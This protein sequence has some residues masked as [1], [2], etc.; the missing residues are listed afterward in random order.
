MKCPKCSY[1]SE[2]RN[3]WCPGCGATFSVA[4]LERLHQLEYLRQRLKWWA[5]SKELPAAQV[6]GVLEEVDSDIA[7]LRARLLPA[8]PVQKEQEPLAPPAPASARVELPAT[9]AAPPPAAAPALSPIA[10][11]FWQQPAASEP[12]ARQPM[13]PAPKPQPT[14]PA[15]AS[16]RAAASA[17]ANVR[18]PRPKEI[19][20]PRPTAPSLPSISLPSISLPKFKSPLP[21]DF[22]WRQLGSYLTSETTL[23]FLLLLGSIAILISSAVIS[24]GNPAGLGPWPHLGAVLFTTALFYG[25]G[26]FVLRRLKQFIPGTALLAIGGAFIALDIFTLGQGQLLRWP[27]ATIWLVASLVCL[28]AYAASH[29]VLRDRPFAILTTLAGGSLVLS[30]LYV[31]GLPLEWIVVTLGPLAIAYALASQR[32]RATRPQLAWAFFWTP[33]AAVPLMMGTLTL[34]KFAAPQWESAVGAEA[35]EYA[36]GGAWWLGAGYYALCARL[37]GGRAYTYLAAWLTPLAFLLTL[38]KAPWGAEWYGACLAALALAYLVFGVVRPPVLPATSES[39]LAVRL[40]IQPVYQV[41]F[42]LTLAALFWPFATLGATALALFL[43]AGAYA[44]AYRLFHLPACRYAAVYLPA[45]GLGFALLAAGIEGAWHS[46]GFAVLALVYLGS[47]RFVLRVGAERAAPDLVRILAREP[48][49]QVAALLTVVATFWPLQH[50]ESR[51][52]TLVLLLSI[53]WGAY[54]LWRLLALRYLAAYLPPVVAG[55]TLLQLAPAATVAGLAWHNA[56]YAALALA[57]LLLGHFRLAPTGERGRPGLGLALRREPL[58]QVATLLTVLALAWPYS[59]MASRPAAAWLVF[60]TYALAAY[61]WRL[62]AP[63]YVAAYLLPVAAYFSLEQTQPVILAWWG[64]GFALLAVGYLL[65]GRF[66]LDRGRPTK[67]GSVLAEPVYQVAVLLTGA[68]LAWPRSDYGAAAAAFF[69]VAAGYALGYYLLRLWALRY[70]AAYALPMAVGLTV[71]ARAWPGDPSTALSTQTAIFPALALAYLL[72]GRFALRVAADDRGPAAGAALALEPIYQVA[73]LLTIAPLT[74]AGSAKL[75]SVLPTLWLAFAVYA[76]GAYL[77]CWRPLRYAA[78]YLLPFAVYAVV[79]QAQPAPVAWWGVAA[80][81]LALTYLLFGRFVLGL[82]RPTK[83]ATVLAEP[84]YQVAGLLSFV[85]VAWPRSDYGAAAGA[86]FLVATGYALGYYLLR[87]WALRYVAA[88][89]LPVAVGLT[90]L[91]RAWPG[92]A[93]AALSWREPAF[94]VLALAYLLIG[95]FV[96][97]AAADVRGPT[98][99]AALA[100]DPIYQVAALLTLVPAFLWISLPVTKHE[101]GLLSLWLVFAGYALGAWLWRWR[102]LRYVAAYLLPVAMWVSL[103]RL[104]AP[105]D[106]GDWIWW[107]LYATFLALGYLLCGRFA[108]Q[109][110]RGQQRAEPV[111]QVMVLLSLLALVWPHYWTVGTDHQRWATTLTWLALVLVWGTTAFLLERR[112]WAYASVYLLLPTL[113]AVLYASEVATATVPP[114]WALLGAALLAAAEVVAR[115]AGEAR[116]PLWE[117]AVG[118]GAWRS[119]FASPLFGAGY[120]AGLVGLG[121]A[122]DLFRQSEYW[123]GA[124][125]VEAGV[126]LAF[127]VVVATWAASAATRHTSRFVWAAAWLFLLPFGPAL[128][129]LGLQPATT[130]WPYLWAALGVSYLGLALFV[131]RYGGH[132]AKPLHLVGNVLLVTTMFLSALDRPSN[133]ALVGFNVLVF[134]GLAWLV[135]RDRHPSHI[136]LVT[137][138]FSDQRSLEHRTARAL[139]VYLAVWLFP[140]WLLLAINLWPPGWRMVHYGLALAVLAP[141]YLALG[142]F[143]RRLRLEY[144]VP[145]YI[146]AIVLSV[147]GAAVASAEPTPRALGLALAIGL[148]V[149]CARLFR[150]SGWLYP[151]TVLGAGLQLQMWELLGWEPQGFGLG[152]MALAAFYGVVGQAVQRDRLTISLRPLGGPLRAYTLPYFAVGYLFAALGLG[153]AITQ[154]RWTAAGALALGALYYLASARLF[155][156]RLFGYLVAASAAAAYIVGLT[157][158]G[159]APRFFGLALVPGVAACYVVAEQLRR[160]LERPAPETGSPP[161]ANLTPGS[162]ASPFYLLTYLGTLVLALLPFEEQALRAVAWLA[163]AAICW[164]STASFKHPLWLYPTIG[165]SV[166]AYLIWCLAL[167]PAL[168]PAQMLALLAVP[169]WVLWW[170]CALWSPRAR[171]FELRHHSPLA[172]T[173]GEGNA[174]LLPAHLWGWALLGV[175]TLGSLADPGTG[176]VVAVAYAALLATFAPR[177]SSK[178]ELWGSLAFAG[179]AYEQSVI[180]TGVPLVSQPPYWAL[181]ALLLTLLAF[182]ARRGRPAALA[183]WREPFYRASLVL[184]P[185]S[186][187]AAAA[188]LVTN[189]SAW[190]GDGEGAVRQSLALT[191]AVCGA[192]LLT[193][194]FDRHDRRLGYLG[195]GLMEVGY[196]LQLLFGGY[197]DPQLY[198]VAGGAYLYGVAVLEW[199]R[200]ARGAIK[201]VLESAA[202]LTILLVTF[203]QAAGFL[204]ADYDRYRYGTLLLLQSVAFISAGALLGWK[205]SFFGGGLAM[206]A[207]IVLMLLDPARALLEWSI[208]IATFFFG[209]VFVAVVVFLT[210]WRNQKE[211]HDAWRQ[212]LETWD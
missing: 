174:W 175:S 16:A 112:R 108:L 50:A 139:F 29:L 187:V 160:R 107:G 21:E 86:F 153:Q 134:A 49:Y 32:L 201:H 190:G 212:R 143:S 155:R 7:R 96:L 173:S 80:A 197:H 104:Q 178:V 150:R 130:A 211:L 41:A 24:I 158:L 26:F 165:A 105:V 45:V 144:R 48:L 37:H 63:R 199:R 200:G 55:L 161:W 127:L 28:A 46:L 110:S 119:R 43:V 59:S 151:A 152:L 70:V 123:A 176:L 31:V 73:A 184:A 72:F 193:H 206:L 170:A 109:V 75:E 203:S 87:L 116:R 34:A 22:A 83:Y 135:H 208:W 137:R 172:L 154:T 94:A 192:I 35:N 90:L 183:L 95:R 133:V 81:I 67:Y 4:D 14:A 10:P 204:G 23:N 146:A 181:G 42:V 124:R 65:F 169:T 9:P 60:A 47:G 17:A 36:I 111:Y 126:T 167:L 19:R 77:W 79:E 117:T 136:W 61:L 177:W 166:G 76:L 52:A 102:P 207:D 189:P 171:P 145:W 128:R 98:A 92:D 82:G 3:A 125:Q 78:A 205:K 147:I 66:L 57:Y 210:W 13:E 132:Y 159:V 27:P 188:L 39:P 138:L 25:A 2:Y 113:A 30:A 38:T 58:Y 164:A 99:G 53:Y 1:Q 69:L 101:E 168:T 85:A 179:L 120:L 186:I 54:Y 191:V 93:L 149:A 180:L 163:I 62:S 89:T 56:W 129:L 141:V 148:Y 44:L 142:R 103:L 115:R 114:A 195:V 198:V 131:E 194:G 71:V 84:V 12:P 11:E 74:V 20:A 88:Y 40:L 100:R 157:A 5:V 91:A 18:L 209:L 68:A 140:V 33:Q 64:A 121:T 118:R 162:W 196:A 106:H 182:L 51:L 122:L 15:L 156:Q 185:L 6:D 202:L 97:C 8:P